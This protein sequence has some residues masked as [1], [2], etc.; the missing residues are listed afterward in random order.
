MGKF[1][2]NAI[3][4]RLLFHSRNCAKVSENHDNFESPLCLRGF[5]I[6]NNESIKLVET[7][8]PQMWSTRANTGKLLLQCM[9]TGVGGLIQ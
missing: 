9:N 2:A 6:Y 3:T 7:H 4:P 5:D 8:F 1:G